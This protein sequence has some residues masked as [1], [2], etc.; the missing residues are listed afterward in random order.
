LL[1]QM[2]GAQ[3]IRRWNLRQDVISKKKPRNAAT[4]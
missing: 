1:L 2:W 4:E 3:N